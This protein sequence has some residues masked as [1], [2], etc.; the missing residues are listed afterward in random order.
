MMVDLGGGVLVSDR[1]IVGI[2]DLDITSQSYRTRQYLRE[3]QDRGQILTVDAEELPK[4]FVV[5]AA[6]EEQSVILSPLAPKTLH[7]RVQ[8]GGMGAVG[9]GLV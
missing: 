8:S 2:F 6:G 9:E 7:R 4:S 5:C 1:D 3:A